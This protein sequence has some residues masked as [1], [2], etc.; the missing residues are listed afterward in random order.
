MPSERVQRRIDRLLDEAEEA[1]DGAD[2]DRVRYLCD[3]VLRLDPDNEDAKT[4]AEAAQRDTGLVAA[5]ERKNEPKNA[6]DSTPTVAEPEAPTS[7]ANGRYEVTGF[8]GEG[9][10][11]KVYLV[12]D[13]TLDRDVAFGL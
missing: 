1:A 7:F 10:K 3:Q 13:T 11:K 4:F 5:P 6:S 9:G 12:H 8:L 2:W